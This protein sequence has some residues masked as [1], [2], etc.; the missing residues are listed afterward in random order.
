MNEQAF[1]QE[2]IVD[3]MDQVDLAYYTVWHVYA[4]PHVRM[5]SVPEGNVL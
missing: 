4:L 3:K 5:D 2:L 1:W